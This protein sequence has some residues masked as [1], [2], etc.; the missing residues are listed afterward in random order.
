MVNY[1]VVGVVKRVP[2][3]VIGDGVHTI[4]ELVDIVNISERRMD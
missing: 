3:H 4:K 2:A 1:K